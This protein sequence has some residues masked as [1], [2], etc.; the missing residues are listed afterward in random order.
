MS[1]RVCAGLVRCGTIKLDIIIINYT[2]KVQSHLPLLNENLQ[3]KEMPQNT[4]NEIKM[5][6]YPKLFHLLANKL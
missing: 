1:R 3:A 4:M 2:L 5:T 6:K